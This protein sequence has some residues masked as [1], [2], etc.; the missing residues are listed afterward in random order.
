[1]G[2]Y[3]TVV[4][5][6]SSSFSLFSTLE[7]IKASGF[8]ELFRLAKHI[9]FKPWNEDRAKNFLQL[10]SLDEPELVKYCRGIP[11]L[12]SGCLFDRTT[13]SC[14]IGHEYHVLAEYMSAH[15]VR[16]QWWKERNG[17]VNGGKIGTENA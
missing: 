9:A 6:Q 7:P 1:V 17:P 16:V 10:M 2:H 8:L 13:L 11:K 3:T 5:A 4:V 12:L 15:P 14:I